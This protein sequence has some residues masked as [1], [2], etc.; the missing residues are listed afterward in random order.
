MEGLSVPCPT[1]RAIVADNSQ[2][3]REG[4]ERNEREGPPDAVKF[5]YG[6]IGMAAEK[7]RPELLAEGIQWAKS[8]GKI[9]IVHVETADEVRQAVQDGA[10]GVEHVATAGDLPSDLIDEIVKRGTFVDPTFGEY[11]TTLALTGVAPAERQRKL[12]ERY[13]AIRR[14]SAAGARL[15]VGT[16]TPLVPYGSGFLDEL[17]HFARAGFAPSQI[18]TFATV[19]N[20]AYLAKSGRLGCLD[21]GCEADLV[22]VDQNPLEGLATLRSPV[23]VVREGIVVIQRSHAGGPSRASN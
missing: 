8:H 6:T 22:L 9:S 16:D 10:T 14:L 12:G 3:L 15:T 7:L 17:D 11:Q 13:A 5:I 23:A 21:P 18:L 20:A 1:G 4:L 2:E 19:N